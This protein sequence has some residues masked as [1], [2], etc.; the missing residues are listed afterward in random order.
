MS[1]QRK[2]KI[3]KGEKAAPMKSAT[4]IWEGRR[5]PMEKTV[6]GWRVRSRSAKFPVDYSTGIHSIDAA[7]TA[8]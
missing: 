1:A 7:K 8:A 2:P 6:G 5:L 3:A 4:L